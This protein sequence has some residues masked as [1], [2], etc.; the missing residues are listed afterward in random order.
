MVDLAGTVSRVSGQV[1]NVA[2]ILIAVSVFVALIAG[3][4]IIYF[5]NRRY[6][7]FKCV[8]WRKDAF[9][10]INEEYDRAGIFI[11]PLTKN[12]RFFMQKNNVGLD[13]DHVPYIPSAGVKRVYLIRVGLKNFY[14]IQPNFDG[15]TISF[16]VGEED[17][18]WSIN[19]YERQKRLFQNNPLLQYLP[20]IAIAFTSIIILIIFIYFF[21]E[22]S[23]LK[24]V[25][26]EFGK[27]AK[28]LALLK[29][30]VV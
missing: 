16:T 13:A 2:V 29:S 12:K 3:V 15:E 26:E 17:V 11:D 10:Q 7:E 24:A 19:A 9:G 4:L 23:T 21:K 28:E 18:N 25:A 6:K 8:I 14:F 20:F 27:A 1:L 5:K 22:F 30:K